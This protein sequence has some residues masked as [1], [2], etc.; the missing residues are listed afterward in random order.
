MSETSFRKIWSFFAATGLIFSTYAFL[1]TTGLS[2]K[3]SLAVLQIPATSVPVLALPFEIG[4]L[5]A[6]LWLTRIW[7]REIGGRTWAHRLP[8]LYFSPADVDVGTR[9]GRL[10]QAF[11]LTLTLVAPLL[12]SMHMLVKLLDAEVWCDVPHSPPRATG[13]R[14][15]SHFA[16]VLSREVDNCSML[17]LG[18][19][20]GAEY[21]SWEPWAF[22]LA[23][24]TTTL[25]WCG[26]LRRVFWSR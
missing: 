7:T 25:A 4:V 24:A 3:D 9:G 8:I 15:L 12:F 6:T 1:R 14:G 5:N 10:Y 16:I 11:S 21:F 22:A 13:L 19:I 18:E 17:R 23:M 2:T 20:R 26:T